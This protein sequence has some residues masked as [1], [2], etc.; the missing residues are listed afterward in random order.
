MTVSTTTREKMRETKYD[1]AY[2]LI[3]FRGALQQND[4][5]AKLGITP[6]YLCDLESGRRMP[7]L[8]LINRIADKAG[9]SE[10]CCRRWHRLGAM[11]HG[12]KV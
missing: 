9:R 4:F 12:W 3:K 8:K 7:S 11:A 10:A 2:A 5:A 6:Q 1:F